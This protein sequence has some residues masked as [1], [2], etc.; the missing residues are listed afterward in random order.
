MS[1]HIGYVPGQH[2]AMRTPGF[3]D[4]LKIRLERD[5]Q[6]QNYIVQRSWAILKSYFIDGA[7]IVLTCLKPNI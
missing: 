3:A 2:Q 1:D 4:S 5:V 7:T 6:Y